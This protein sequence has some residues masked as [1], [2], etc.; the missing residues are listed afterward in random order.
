MFNYL[1]FEQAT[2]RYEDLLN[3]ANEFRRYNEVLRASN[4]LNKLV[5]QLKAMLRKPAPE[6]KPAL[7]KGYA[8]Q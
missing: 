3:E 7:R 1:D 4:P 2:H 5:N 6:Q 8:R